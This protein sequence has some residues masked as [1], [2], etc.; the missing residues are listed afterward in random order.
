MLPEKRRKGRGRERGE[1]G[2][3][4]GEEKRG[5]EEKRK[6]IKETRQRIIDEDTRVLASTCIRLGKLTF[7]YTH[8]HTPL[9]HAHK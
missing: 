3:G 9:T 4:E 6:R 8:A 7:M 1:E 2:G 5:G